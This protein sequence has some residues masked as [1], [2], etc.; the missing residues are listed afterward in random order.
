MP[1]QIS[2]YLQKVITE[3]YAIEID[4]FRDKNKSA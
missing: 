4:H 2:L 1:L 3:S